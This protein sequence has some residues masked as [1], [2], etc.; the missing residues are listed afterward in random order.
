MPCC[1]PLG[2]CWGGSWESWRGVRHW[3]GVV[4]TSVGVGCGS[5]VDSE[6]G[7]WEG[8][9]F[10]EGDLEFLWPSQVRSLDPQSVKVSH[11]N[12]PRIQRV[13]L[14]IHRE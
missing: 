14:G 5:L 2:F 9:L 4:A 1:W 11:S 10:V 7:G 3:W 8:E 13:W 6:G 12:P